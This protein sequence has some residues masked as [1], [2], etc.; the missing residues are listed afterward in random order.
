MLT[1]SVRELDRAELMRRIHEGRLSQPRAA[2]Q[3]GVSVRQVERMYRAYQADGPAALVSK[4]RGRPSNHRLAEA[5]RRE[6]LKLVRE[7]YEGFGPTL[8]HEKLV[9]CH[10]VRVSVETLRKWMAAD[11]LWAPRAERKKRVQ[12]PRARRPCRGELVQ[13][14]GCNH[15]W[16]ERRGPR[17]VLL[18]YVDDATSELMELRFV[19]SESTFDYF[20]STKRYLERHGKP[21]ALYSDKAGVFRVNAKAPAG[22][23]GFT[24]FGR[25]MHELNVDVICANTAPAKGRVERAHQTMQ[26]RLV[27]ELRLRGIC[28]MDD[29]NAFLP[30][31]MADYNRRFGKAPQSNHDAHR[32]LRVGEKLEQV[33]LW[34]EDRRLSGNLT[35]HYKRMLYLVEPS[36]EAK[37]LRGKRVQ[38]C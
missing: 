3:L 26:D 30:H 19:K 13:I 7:R 1:M 8:A 20:A 27:K 10:G 2:E 37:R 29:G 36:A 24:Q 38:V 32:P 12:Q 15:E 23:D 25:A 9:E 34:K 33:F 16:F 11:G 21:V 6:T 18:V 17:C 31:F 22:G 28:S 4:K 14:D 35:L 5:L